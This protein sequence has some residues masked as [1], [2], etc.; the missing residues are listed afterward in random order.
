MVDGNGVVLPP[1]ARNRYDE[2]EMVIVMG[3]L[4]SHVPRERAEAYVWRVTPPATTW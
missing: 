1:D 3:T 4:P 2:G